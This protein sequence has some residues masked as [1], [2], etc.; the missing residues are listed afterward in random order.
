MQVLIL[1]GSDEKAKEEIEELK[2]EAEQKKDKRLLAKII[3][4]EAFLYYIKKNYEKAIEGCKKA[5]EIKPDMY[6][7]WCNLGVAY[8]R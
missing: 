6:E 5:I 3:L 4:G 7:A 8:T 1:S 2:K